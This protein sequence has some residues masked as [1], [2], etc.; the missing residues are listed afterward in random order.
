MNSGIPA[1]LKGRDAKSKG[2][3][4][5]IKWPRHSGGKIS[6]DFHAVKHVNPLNSQ[7]SDY[8]GFFLGFLE[9]WTNENPTK[10]SA[11]KGIQTVFM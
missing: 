5:Y 7:L 4:F 9:F 8:F 3:A 10:V 11:S 1:P 6:S 2:K